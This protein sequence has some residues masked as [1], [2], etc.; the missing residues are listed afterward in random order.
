MVPSV[1]LFAVC[2][3]LPVWLLLLLSLLLPLLGLPGGSDQ[4]WLWAVSMCHAP[5]G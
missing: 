2:V 3:L 1:G 5:V 4:R